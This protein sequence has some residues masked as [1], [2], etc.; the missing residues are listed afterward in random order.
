MQTPIYTVHVQ[1]EYICFNYSRRET[2]ISRNYI[3]ITNPPPT[4][5]IKV[6]K[7]KESKRICLTDFV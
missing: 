1:S 2:M 6:N 5:K 4:K 7:G 3:S